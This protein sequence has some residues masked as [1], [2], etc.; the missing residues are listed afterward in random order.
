[1]VIRNLTADNDLESYKDM[2]DISLGTNYTGLLFPSEKFPI[3]TENIFGKFVGGKLVSALFLVDY[4]I[5][6]RGNKFRMAGVEG[7]TTLPGFR[8]KGFSKEI[9]THIFKVMNERQQYLSVLFPTSH[10]LYER[11]GYGIADEQVFYQFDLSNI[12]KKTFPQHSFIPVKNFTTGIKQFYNECTRKFDFIALRDEFSW[13]LKAEQADFYF[14][15]KDV[16]EDTVGYCLLKFL[17][18]HYLFKDPSNT[19][20]IVEAFWKD[21]TT[22]HALFQDFLPSFSDQRKYGSVVLPLDENFIAMVYNPILPTRTIKVSSRIRV[23][24][25]K[26]VLKQLSYSVSSFSISIKVSDPYCD[27][28]N[29]TFNLYKNETQINVEETE[30]IDGQVDLVIDIVA[31]AELIVGSKSIQDLSEFPGCL[32][33]SGSLELLQELFPKQKNYFRDF[34]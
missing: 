33:N 15:S 20:H 27:W 18:A 16:N 12:R 11:R 26:K 2:F 8:G 30:H 25:V 5:K 4:D 34:F 9:F 19:I 23:I 6:L 22:K 29:K 32:V 17:K 31:F 7:V 10:Y 24:N 3:P 28:N 1:M 14:E 21:R 13:K